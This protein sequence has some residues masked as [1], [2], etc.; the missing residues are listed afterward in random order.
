MPPGAPGGKGGLSIAAG[1]GNRLRSPGGVWPALAINW[2]SPTC[3]ANGGA[4]VV[5]F[6]PARNGGIGGTARGLLGSPEREKVEEIN[7]P[8][9]CTVYTQ[10]IHILIV[11]IYYKLT[12]PSIMTVVTYT[13]SRAHTCCT[14]K[15][16]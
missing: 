7:T 8:V 3:P 9:E 11:S 15:E 10:A 4:I 1:W 5:G 2:D 14:E 13:R 12:T 6:A 16:C